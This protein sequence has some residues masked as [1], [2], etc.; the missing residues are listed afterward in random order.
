[1]YLSI[2]LKSGRLGQKT[3]QTSKK[4]VARRTFQEMLFTILLLTYWNPTYTQRM[5]SYDFA[6][7]L[8]LPNFA[9]F[10]GF[11]PKVG[12]INGQVLGNN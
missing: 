5:E 11:W 7:I 10:R 12:H 8:I 4:F 6:T 2:P 3:V 9:I 1:M